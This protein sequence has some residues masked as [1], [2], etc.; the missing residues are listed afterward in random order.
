MTHSPQLDGLRGIAILGVLAFHF[1]ATNL[2]QFGLAY[3][4]ALFDLGWTI[5]LSFVLSG[6]LITSMLAR[7]IDRPDFYRSF[8]IRRTLRIFP[9][10]YLMLAAAFLV[11]QDLGSIWKQAEVTEWP[12]FVL[13]LSNIWLGAQ[14]G[15][16]PMYALL[17]ITWTL[18]VQEQFYLL[19]PFVI[20]LVKRPAVVCIALI[21]ASPFLRWA[22][23]EWS[24]NPLLTHF[25]LTSN[26][27]SL[28]IGAL[29]VFYRPRYGLALTAGSGAIL[30]ALVAVYG[31]A[32]F[33]GAW[34]ASVWFAVLFPSLLALFFGGVLLM[35]LEGGL[36][37]R[38]LSIKPL[39]A[40]GKI[41]YG[42]YLYHILVSYLITKFVW[43]D[44]FLPIPGNDAP[45]WVVPAVTFARYSLTI[46]VA[47]LSYRYLEQPILAIKDWRFPK[48]AP[49]QPK[50]ASAP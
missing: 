10:Y 2:G 39:T 35:A 6:F 9:A 34:M 16:T 5:V 15:H 1:D 22:M 3:H 41:S 27:D 8:Y 32:Y 17:G 42:V 12:Y 37:A 36:L 7:S 26:L 28:A 43:A 14:Q 45:A 40:L 21:L 19:W 25:S 4:F 48:F 46:L 23:F 11:A 33:A 50:P 29:I 49:I 20:R 47:A 44:V 38:C 24:G 30:A 31:P 18:A 13:Y